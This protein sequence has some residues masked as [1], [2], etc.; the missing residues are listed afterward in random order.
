[1]PTLHYNYG[2]YT[3]V[4]FIWRQENGDPGNLRPLRRE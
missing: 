3:M 1:M 4:I 2:H